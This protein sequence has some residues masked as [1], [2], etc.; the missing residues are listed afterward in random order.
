MD[1]MDNTV[2]P[3]KNRLM[4]VVSLATLAL[5]VGG[6]W[7][8]YYNRPE[9]K[10]SRIREQYFSATPDNVD[11]FAV[12]K[13]ME[14]LL[15]DS[16]PSLLRETEAELKAFL[17]D[18][19]SEIDRR[20][21]T[22]LLKEV[23]INP[24]YPNVLRVKALTYIA[25]HYGLD[26][27]DQ[28]FARDITFTGEG[29]EHLLSESGGDVELAMRKLNEWSNTLLPNLT[30]NYRVALW[31]AEEIHKNAAL[32]DEEKAELLEKMRAYLAEGDKILEQVKQTHAPVRLAIASALKA[33]IVDLSEG[34]PAEADK[35]FRFAMREYSRQPFTVLQLVHLAN[36]GL[37][38]AAFL[39]RQSQE[40]QRQRIIDML[41]PIYVYLSTPQSPE[42]RNVRLV[43]LL[44]AARDSATSD[45][46]ALDF[47]KSDID[48]ISNIYPEFGQM[49]DTLDL[50]LYAKDHPAEAFIK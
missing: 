40:E 3:Q 41:E 15:A 18:S 10:A 19:L 20:R 16:S 21:G 46:P 32:Q 12:A 6:A 22:E 42:K 25:D 24:Q 44:V 38:Y 33:R 11:F 26:F 31:Y 9:Q 49:I 7:L 13:N 29:F 35:F 47:N 1:F 27:T 45:Y 30:A 48:R 37:Y 36:D 23:A 5:V 39:A 2:E 8:Y 34:D 14:K 17:G 43:S 28:N 4:V 50:K